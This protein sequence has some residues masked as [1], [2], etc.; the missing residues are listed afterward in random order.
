MA[1]GEIDLD[2][3]G[4]GG[5]GDRAKRPAMTVPGN[6]G[7]SHLKS[8]SSP[9][10]PLARVTEWDPPCAPLAKTFM[11]C[12]HFDVQLRCETIGH[13]AGGGEPARGVEQVSDGLL[14]GGELEALD[15]AVF[16]AGDGAFVNEGPVVLAG[17]ERFGGR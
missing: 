3:A 2:V 10:L 11:P 12:G 6:P 7:L 17:G 9:G 8:Y 16:I 14:D 4:A 1:D 5:E 13:V 15:G